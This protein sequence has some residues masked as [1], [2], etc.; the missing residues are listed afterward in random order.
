MLNAP[1]SVPRRS[2]ISARN[3]SARTAVAVLS[4]GCLSFGSVSCFFEL[5]PLEENPPG[6]G[7]SPGLGGGGSPPEQGG[8]SGA[9]TGGGGASGVSCSD[10][11]KACGDQCQP[12]TL[13]FGC[14]SSSCERCADV[15]NA[16]VDCVNGA[17]AVQGCKPGFADCDGDTLNAVGEVASNG[18]E[19]ELGAPAPA[20]TQMSVPF[21]TI[22]VDGEREDW[23]DLPSYAFEQVCANCVDQVT[24]PVTADGTVPPRDDLDARFR[25]AWDADKLY[26]LVEAFDNQVYSTGAPGDR[27][28]HA[29]CEDA[30]QVILL[31]RGNRAEG[32]YNDNKRIFLGSSQRFS[33]PS[34]QQPVSSDVELKVGRTGDFCYRIEAQVDWAFITLAQN[35]TVPGHFPPAPGQS[36]GF[37][38]A[39]NDW[40][41]PVSDP[42]GIQRQ[43]QIFWQDPG[44]GYAMVPA[45]IG[46]MTLL[47]GSDAG[48]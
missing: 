47:G 11:E 4:L 17:C 33:A 24:P 18:C 44:P 2:L 8:S 40:D 41:A 28:Q 20:V 39:L 34:Q 1:S 31:G 21:R 23:S 12:T 13:E 46:T 19:Y 27:C 26:L 30:V 45:D 22:E 35:G 36:Y 37:D 25:V 15:P 3:T 32:Y 6:L 48:E 14:S 5:P 16:V 9:G 7:G 10:G 43:S 38:I 29:E 42:A